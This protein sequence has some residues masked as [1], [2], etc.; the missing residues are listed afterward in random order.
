M[1]SGV[2]LSR[3]IDFPRKCAGFEI[4]M[5]GTAGGQA[6]QVSDCDHGALGESSVTLTFDFE[7]AKALVD[8]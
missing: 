5:V 1:R 2:S 6:R 3:P 4:E 8:F 7:G